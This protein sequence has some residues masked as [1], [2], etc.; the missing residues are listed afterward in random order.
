MPTSDINSR[1]VLIV[2][3]ICND[4]KVYEEIIFS[5]ASQYKSQ[6]HFPSQNN[7]TCTKL[8]SSAFSLPGIYSLST[9]EIVPVSHALLLPKFFLRPLVSKQRLTRGPVICMNFLGGHFPFVSSPLPR[10]TIAFLMVRPLSN[11][12][13]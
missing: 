1:A 5:K 9:R 12:A 2:R 3:L 13:K 11:R 7:R 8:T 4:E 10:P 6:L